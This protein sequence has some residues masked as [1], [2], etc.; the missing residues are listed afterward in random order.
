MHWEK[1]DVIKEG[2]LGKKLLLLDGLCQHAGGSRHKLLLWLMDPMKD[3][4]KI[5]NNMAF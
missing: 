3:L 4:L 5:I 2:K 1:M